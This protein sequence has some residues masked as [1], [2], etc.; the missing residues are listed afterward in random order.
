VLITRVEPLS[1]SSDAGL[2]R[3]NVLLEVNRKPVPSVA[4]YR[5]AASAA[6]PGDILTL[7]LYA[8]DVGQR[9]LKT[10]RVEDR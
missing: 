10:V 2:Q 5:R 9:Q 8:P 1:A 7:Y 3:G 4:E 6:R